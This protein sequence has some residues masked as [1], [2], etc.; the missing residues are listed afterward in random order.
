MNII[1][2]MNIVSVAAVVALGTCAIHQLLKA[3]DG[4]SFHLRMHD[5]WRKLVR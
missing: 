1:V 4:K 2:F 5:V 3:R